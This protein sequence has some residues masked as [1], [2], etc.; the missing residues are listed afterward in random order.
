MT[1]YLN[2]KKV[3][4]FRLI[5]AH[6]DPSAILGTQSIVWHYSVVLADVRIGDH[7]S[8]GSRCEIGRGSVIG[9]YSRIGSGVFLPPNSI[10][11]ERVFVGP[12]VTCT[13]DR[14]PRVP[15]A[16]DPPYVALPPIIK[17]DVAIGAGAVILPGVTIGRGAR[18]AAGAV[19]TDDVPPFTMVVGLPAR[20]R[21]MP[22]SWGIAEMVPLPT[23]RLL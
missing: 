7:V 1:D 3:P 6:I 13:D 21:A 2:A 17:D 20:V 14:H 22:E 4:G 19:V 11:G 15:V 10:V 8:I 18:I 5:E 12:N 16:G 9:D 23:S